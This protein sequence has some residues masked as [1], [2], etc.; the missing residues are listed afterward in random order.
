MQYIINGGKKLEG[1]IT[2]SGSKNASLPIIAGA[3]LSGKTST[4]YNVP[5]I[6]DT[7]ITLEILELLGCKVVRKNGK[8]II[9]SRY[10]Q[11]TEIPNE[12]MHKLRSSII[13]AG[14]LIG[15]FKKAVFSYPGGCDIGSRPIDLHIKTLQKLGINI[16]EDAGYIICKCDKVVG[17]D[18]QLDFPSVGATENIMLASVLAEGETTITNSAMEPEIVDLQNFLNRMG[19]KITGAGTKLIKIRG[20]KNLKDVSYNVMPDRIEIG[21]FLCMTMITGGHTQITG[22]N[23]EDL[24]SIIAKLEEAGAKIETGKNKIEI[25]APKKIKA[26]EIKTHPYPGFPTDMQS[27]FGAM[28]TIAKGT[29]VIVENI[30]ENR[31]KYLNELKKM[32]AKVSQEGKVAIIKGT[33]KLHGVEMNATDLRGGAAMCLAGLGATGESKIKNIEYIL[34]GYENLDKKLHHLGADIKMEK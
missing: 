23:N 2:A 13:L 26:V 12:L 25:I 10:M 19:A 22:V 8:I 4:L 20:V 5:N 33:K 28:L 7:K 15:R 32:G 3:I 17:A 11:K 31:F 1:E 30:F 16:E 29:S 24:T 14:A 9:D 21:T 18:I 27:V 34:R 6:G